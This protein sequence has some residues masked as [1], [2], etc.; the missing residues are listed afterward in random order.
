MILKNE[1]TVSSFFT[2]KKEYEQRL[3]MRRDYLQDEVLPS[4]TQD[5]DYDDY[6][7]FQNEVSLIEQQLRKL[8]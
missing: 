3:L 4:L 8:Y 6:M 7:Y 1:H 2:I 5:G